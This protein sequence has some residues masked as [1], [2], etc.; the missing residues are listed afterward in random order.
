[1]GFIFTLHYYFTLHLYYPLLLHSSSLLYIITSLF[2]FTLHYYFTLHLYYTLLLHSSSLLY[3]IYGKVG[4]ISPNRQDTVPEDRSSAQTVLCRDQ[5]EV[6]GDVVVFCYI[7][8]GRL[9]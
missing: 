5:N 9:A 2:L 7:R 4:S 3:I 1:M 6:Q 8:V